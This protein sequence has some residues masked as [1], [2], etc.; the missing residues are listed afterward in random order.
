MGSEGLVLARSA[1]LERPREKVHQTPEINPNIVLERPVWLMVEGKEGGY[2]N[3]PKKRRDETKQPLLGSLD[4]SKRHRE[5]PKHN[6][7][8]RNK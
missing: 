8:A 6:S 3:L 7:K 1:T 2:V 5:L 4:A